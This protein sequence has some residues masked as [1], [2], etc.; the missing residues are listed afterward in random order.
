MDAVPFQERV[1][2]AEV[3]GHRSAA[4]K[5]WRLEGTTHRGWRRWQEQQF[6]QNRHYRPHHR[7]SRGADHCVLARFPTWLLYQHGPLILLH[8]S[9]T[10]R[11]SII[12]CSQA[13][14][15]TKLLGKY[16]LGNRWSSNLSFGSPQTV[17]TSPC[18]WRGTSWMGPMWP[19]CCYWEEIGTRTDVDNIHRSS[20]RKITTYLSW[21]GQNPL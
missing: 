21:H 18:S 17:L 16:A 1:V 2:L 11:G 10:L 14:N 3:L 8:S 6:K 7:E 15:L 5:L 13:M 4:V 12:S 19:C 20:G 9:T